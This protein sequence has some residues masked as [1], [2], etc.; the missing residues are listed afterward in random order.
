M[1]T[2]T[3]N[4]THT[5]W[6]DAAVDGLLSGVA[7]GAVMAAYLLAAGWAAGRGWDW[8]LR[9]FD[10]GA[11]PTPFIG[12]ATHLAV[13]GVYGLAFGGL[14]RPI[15]RVWRRPRPWL[16]GLSYGLLLWLLALAVLSS[17]S[18]GGSAFLAGFGPLPLA[19]AH[20]VYGLALGWLVGRF[21]RG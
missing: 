9:Q 4:H 20:A 1:E 18:S 6:G 12:A 19:V 7:A 8:V 14:W 13:S 15:A 5:G 17:R 2:K 11:A 16:A 21:Q 3:L 10:P